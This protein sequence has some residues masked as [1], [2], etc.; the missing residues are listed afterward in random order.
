MT[1]CIEVRP[2]IL[3]SQ[4]SRTS[5]PYIITTRRG[6]CRC[7]GEPKALLRKRVSPPL[8]A[9]YSPRVVQIQ[10]RRGCYDYTHRSETAD[11]RIIGEGASSDTIDEKQRRVTEKRQNT[12]RLV[13]IQPRRGRHDYTHHRETADSRIAIPMRPAEAGTIEGG[14]V[15]VKP[16]KGPAG[17][18]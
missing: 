14:R 10:P 9:I 6:R 1:T 18:S 12:P 16:T 2:R 4:V 13:Q 7:R 15:Q 17:P 8:C 5:S 11:S 3:G